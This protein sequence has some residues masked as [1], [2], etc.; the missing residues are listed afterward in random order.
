MSRNIPYRP[1]PIKLINGIGAVLAKVG[2]QPALTAND[3]FKRVE[4]ETGLTR[5]SHGWDAGGLDVL[6]NALNTEAQLW[7]SEPALQQG[8]PVVTDQP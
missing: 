2:I 1:L 8:V 5:P 7:V 6:L 4:K 3:I